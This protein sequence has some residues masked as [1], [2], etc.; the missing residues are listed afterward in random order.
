[1]GY[2]FIKG[3]RPYQGK[4]RKEIKEKIL[5]KQIQIRKND[6]PEGWSLEA[7]DFVN[8]LIQRKPHHRLGNRGP[9]EVQMHPWFKGISWKDLYNHREMSP[10]IPKKKDNF[11]EKYCNQPDKTGIETEERYNSIIRRKDYHEIFNEYLYFNREENKARNDLFLIKNPHE[12]YQENIEDDDENDKD[13][14]DNNES[15]NNETIETAYNKY[16]DDLFIF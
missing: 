9:K 1:M 4:S 14:I 8:R 16:S 2:E 13:D 7:C 6:I 12:Q 3:H 5:S 11:D 10:Y 15:N